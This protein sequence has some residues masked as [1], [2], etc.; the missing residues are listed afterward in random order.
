MTKHVFYRLT[1]IVSLVIFSSGLFATHA[2]AQNKGFFHERAIVLNMPEYAGIQ[3]TLA[4][5]AR[6]NQTEYEQRVTSFQEDYAAYMQKRGT[7]NENEQAQREQELA[8]RQQEIR[9]APTVAQ[10]ELMMKQQELLEPLFTK[11]QGALETV[12]EEEDLEVIYNIEALSY[13][14]EDEFVN[15]TPLVAEELGLDITGGAA[16]P[17]V[18]GGTPAPTTP[19]TPGN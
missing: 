10:E 1:A 13:I 15:V 7:L 8:R 9:Q 5:Q 16:T 19:G 12:A 6:T 2:S 3:Q 18:G 11:I 17:G 4:R 14:D